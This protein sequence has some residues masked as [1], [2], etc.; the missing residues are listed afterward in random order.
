MSFH[1]VNKRPPSWDSIYVTGGYKKELEEIVG[2]KV[3]SKQDGGNWIFLVKRK[4][5]PKLRED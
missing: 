5:L 1:I 3:I 2:Y 4:D